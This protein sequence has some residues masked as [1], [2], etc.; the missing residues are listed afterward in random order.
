MARR[1]AP[2]IR[3][4]M[5]AHQGMVAPSGAPSPSPPGEGLAKT[6]AE[7]NVTAR[8]AGR[9]E[10]EQFGDVMET[11]SLS[12]EQQKP[13]CPGNV[14]AAGYCELG[15]QVSIRLIGSGG[16]GTG[17]RSAMPAG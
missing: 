4:W 2:R 9:L 3:K 13:Y 17:P 15:S 6:P 8:G 11:C 5:R 12:R 14:P 1:K 10:P 16:Q 7:K